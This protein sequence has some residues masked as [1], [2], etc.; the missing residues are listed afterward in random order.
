MREHIVRRALFD[1][2]A[3]ALKDDAI[4]NLIDET[5]LMG[6]DDHGQAVFDREPRDHV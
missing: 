4:G 1:D 6:G 5:Q 2:H 3:A